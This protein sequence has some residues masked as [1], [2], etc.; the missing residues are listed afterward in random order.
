MSLQI[1][2]P[3]T[4][5]PVTVAEVKARL[6]LTTTADD[7]VILSNITAA[8]EFAEKATRRSLAYK[9]Y[10]Y[11]LDRFPCPSEPIRIP[12]PPLIAVTA[13]KYLDGTLTQQTWDPLEY[14]VAPMQSP[15]LIVSKPTFIYP[16]AGPVPGAVEIDFTAG[17]GY[18]G[19]QTPT[20]IPAGPICPE[21]L[22]EGIRQLA[23]HI[24]EHP[25]AVTP[26]GLKEAPLALM[27]FF[28]ANKIYVF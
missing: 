15:A 25:E 7:S 2:T 17:Y 21:H 5:E 3:P 18:P 20:V 6:R 22:K 28:D 26:E 23:V 12:V 8:R 16:C 27:S 1:I 19:Q 24:Y 14:F 9:S 4:A 13:I 10:A 11:F